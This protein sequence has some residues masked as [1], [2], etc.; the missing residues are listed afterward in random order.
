MRKIN[1]SFK[2]SLSKGN[3]FDVSN[4]LKNNPKPM[5]EKS[6]LSQSLQFCV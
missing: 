6:S 1:L 4:A 2:G 3:I 5:A